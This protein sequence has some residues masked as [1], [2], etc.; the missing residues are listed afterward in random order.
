MWHKLYLFFGLLTALPA[1]AVVSDACT[2]L[3]ELECIKSAACILVQL[4]EQRK[5]GSYSCRSVQGRCEKGFQQWGENQVESC[6]S[7]PECKYDPG[8]CYCPPDV[9]CICGG[10]SPPQCVDQKK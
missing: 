8:C 5:I 9:Q 6:E 4:E 2:A 7:K 10:G 3:N 1:M